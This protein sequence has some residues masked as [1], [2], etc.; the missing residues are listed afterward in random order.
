MLDLFTD[1]APT[2]EDL[3][4]WFTPRWACE[5]IVERHFAHLGPSDRVLEP[6]CGPGHFLLALPEDVDA[7]GV[8]IDPALAAQARAATGREVLCGDFLRVAVPGP[9]THIVG[10]PPFQAELVHGFLK[11]AH[12][13]L[14]EGGTCGFLLPSYIFQTSSRVMDL[15]QHWSIEAE[16]LPRNIFP[17]LKLPLVFSMFRKDRARSLVGF[18]LFRET[19]DVSAMPRHIRDALTG[20]AQG[21]VWRAAVR[22][23][24]AT[25]GD[26]AASLDALYAAVERPTENRF[27]REKVRQT[28]QVYPEFARAPDG[29][30]KVAP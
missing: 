5:A 15:N 1:D 3:G 16:L 27:W 20:L 29:R 13:L 9:V 25:V 19:A 14:P 12:Q 7:I 4:Q 17:R 10:N 11:R 8:E 23:A 2:A 6:S 18:F 24:F 21:S 22:A 26:C 28:L 30:W